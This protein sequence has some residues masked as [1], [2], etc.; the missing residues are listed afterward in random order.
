M[1]KDKESREKETKG[2]A[3]NA[4]EINPMMMDQLQQI[5]P[6]NFVQ[7]MMQNP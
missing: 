7:F 3:P 6:E 5:T 2:K 4:Y 1:A